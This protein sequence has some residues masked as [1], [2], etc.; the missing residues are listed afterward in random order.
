MEICR[1]IQTFMASL[2]FKQLY[3]VLVISDENFGLL[4][5]QVEI[6]IPCVNTLVLE[7]EGGEATLFFTVTQYQLQH[8]Y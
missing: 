6:I 4:L 2:L 7:V 1:F 8:V 3:V 5:T